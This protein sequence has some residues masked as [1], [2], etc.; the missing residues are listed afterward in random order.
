MY[1]VS[2][3][4]SINFSSFFLGGNPRGLSCYRFLVLTNYRVIS[5][6]S[7]YHGKTLDARQYKLVNN[8]L[9]YI[10]YSQCF[11]Y[12]LCIISA[13][14]WSKC[15]QWKPW[16]YLRTKLI[17][18]TDVTFIFDVR[19][20]WILTGTRGRFYRGIMLC[21]RWFFNPLRRQIPAL[22]DANIVYQSWGL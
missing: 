20:V 19:E 8:C 6:I 7:F 12:P 11:Q 22:E 3:F 14:I 2:E 1:I 9:Y 21:I 18:L 13:L 10:H 4:E 16:R 5:L 17:C 15:G